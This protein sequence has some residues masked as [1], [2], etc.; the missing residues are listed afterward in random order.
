LLL[1]DWRF[2][3][4]WALLLMLLPLPWVTAAAAAAAFHELCHLIA[5][6]LS[7]GVVHSLRISVGGAVMESYIPDNKKELLCALAGPLGSFFLLAFYHSFP[8]LALCAAVQGS[9][10]LLPLYP[11]DGGRV[12]RCALALFFPEKPELAEQIEGCAAILILSAAVLGAIVF[13]S[14]LLLYF[15]AVLLAKRKMPCKQSRIGVQ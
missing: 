7:G 13:R 12:L 10:N 8:R 3:L 6:L 5:V 11:L 14:L 15:C 9:F 1:V 2:C 4:L